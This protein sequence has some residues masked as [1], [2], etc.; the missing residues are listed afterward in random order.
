MNGTGGGGGGVEYLYSS[1][2]GGWG[3][4]KKPDG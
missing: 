4:S 1:A 3:Y 2:T